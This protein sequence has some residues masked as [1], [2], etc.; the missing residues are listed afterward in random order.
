[1]KKALKL[2]KPNHKKSILKHLEQL[3]IRTI[4]EMLEGQIKL[5][6]KNLQTNQQD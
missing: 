5:K 4:L 3:E 6:T 1:M 2:K